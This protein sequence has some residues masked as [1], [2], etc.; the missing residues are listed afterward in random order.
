MHARSYTYFG[1][2]VE[3]SR[4]DISALVCS[5]EAEVEEENEY[6][7]EDLTS[8][9]DTSDEDEDEAKQFFEVEQEKRE[10]AEGLMKQ[11]EDEEAYEDAIDSAEV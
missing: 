4:Y 9:W 10:I 11:E 8:D 3:G 1:I 7:V 6:I 5:V 2:M